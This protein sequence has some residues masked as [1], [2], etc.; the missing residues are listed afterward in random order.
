MQPGRPILAGPLV[1]PLDRPLNRPLERP[2]ERPLDRPLVRPLDRPLARPLTCPLACP[3]AASLAGSVTIH[4]AKK[5][6]A[7]EPCLA[8]DPFQPFETEGHPNRLSDPV[9]LA[10]L[11]P[12]AFQAHSTSP[13]KL[14]IAYQV[15]KFAANQLDQKKYVCAYRYRQDQPKC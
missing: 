4:L 14:V 12:K 8:S 15:S 13:I 10:K 11:G 7:R 1:G 6:P 5:I 2:L 3:L 9:D